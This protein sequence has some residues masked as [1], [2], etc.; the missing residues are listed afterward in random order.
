M[1]PTGDGGEEG[2]PCSICLSNIVEDHKWTLHCGHAFHVKC[3]RSWMFGDNGHRNCPYCRANIDYD[4]IKTEELRAHIREG[5]VSDAVSLLNGSNNIDVN[6][7]ISG[8]SMIF[9]ACNK[10]YTDLMGPLY[11]EF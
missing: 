6:A 7:E 9:E 4:S 8:L 5:R 11:R 3:L 1:A 10:G 2:C